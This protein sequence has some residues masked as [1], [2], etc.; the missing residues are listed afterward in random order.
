MRYI[1]HA[2]VDAPTL[3][4]SSSQSCMYIVYMDVENHEKGS[5]SHGP[6]IFTGPCVIPYVRLEHLAEGDPLRRPSHQNM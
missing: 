1:R 4:Q 3:H 5:S 2:Y 6:I